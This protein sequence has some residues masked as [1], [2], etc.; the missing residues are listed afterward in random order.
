[1]V[2]YAFDLVSK[3][4]ESNAK[5]QKAEADRWKKAVKETVARHD[6][7]RGLDTSRRTMQDVFSERGPGGPDNM[8][9]LP[10]DR[11]HS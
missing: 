9:E 5:K 2:D 3:A 8:S 1:M 10:R 7:S 11:E 4:M 6:E